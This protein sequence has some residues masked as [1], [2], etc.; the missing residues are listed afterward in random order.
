MNPG[1]FVCA[2]QVGK[3]ALG[4]VFFY[5]VE[6]ASLFPCYQSIN[7][8]SVPFMLYRLTHSKL[9]CCAGPV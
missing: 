7:F 1:L 2:L 3:V 6:F 5:R 9:C 4:Q 8:L